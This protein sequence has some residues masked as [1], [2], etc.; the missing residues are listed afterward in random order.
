MLPLFVLAALLESAHPAPDR[1]AAPADRVRVEICETGLLTANAWPLA[2]P[3]AATE[4]F[5]APAFAF[6]RLPHKYIDT[7]VRADRPNPFLLRAVARVTLPAGE[8]RLLLRGR[9]AARLFVDGRLVLNTPFPPSLGDGSDGRD[10]STWDYLNLGPDFRFAPPGNREAWCRFKSTGAEHLVVLE[11]V[12]GGVIG[13]RPRR[14]ELG[15]T[16][17]VVSPAGSESFALLGPGQRVPYTDAAWP[18]FAAAE[19]TRLAKLDADRRAAAFASEKGPWDARR[20]D[21]RAW[22]AANPP[23]P[24]PP[25]PKGFTAGNPVDHFVAAKIAAAPTG[26]EGTVSYAKDVRPILEAKCFSCH[27]GAKAKAGL[28]LDK[29]SPAVVP[30]KPD[31]SDLIARATATDAA[32]VMPPKGERLTAGEV[33]LLKQW[34]AEGALYTERPGRVT[35]LTDD[36]AFLRRVTLG[37]VGVVPT[38]DEIAAFR[39]DRAPDRRAKVI[40]RL[41]VDPR[42]AGH[43]VGYWQDVLAEN[44]NILNPTLNNTGPF[45]WWLHEAYRDNKPF[46]VMVTE[47]VRMRG[48]ERGGGPAGF[49]VASENDVPMAEKAVTVAA[50]FLGANMKCARCHD[51]PA[52]RAT[53]QELFQLAGLLAGKPLKVPATSSVPLDKLGGGGR[54]PLIK[55]TLKPGTTV[56]PAWPFADFLKATA[57]APR[58]V[59]SRDRLAAWLTDPRNERFAQVV[60]NR[61]WKRL[62][63][64]GLVEPADDWERGEPSHPELLTYLARELVRSGYD[65]RHVERLI[66][67]SHAYQRAA[68]PGRAAPDPFF[69]SPVRRRLTAEQV[70][71]SLFA[72]AGKPLNV[73]EVS[74]DID[75][76]RDLGN[77]ISLGVPRRAWEF[78]STSNERDRPSLALPRVQAVVDA[79]AAF[80]WRATRPDALTDR[81]TAPDVLQ[82][83]ALSNGTVA[84]WLTRLSDDHAVA[85]LALEAKTPEAFVDALFLRVLTR[86]PTARERAALV[87]HVSVGFEGRVLA[88]PPVP[89]GAGPRARPRYVSWSNH[90]TPGANDLKT[91][92]ERQARAGDPPTARLTADWRTRAE[93]ALWA[94]LNAPEFVF[95]P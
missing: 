77:S 56:D 41:L 90:L 65:L 64:M 71:D 73:G 40:D 55:V 79:L 63:G 69:A 86:P 54:Q 46:D 34:I 50:A 39:A 87:D 5:D 10:P 21:A 19:E 51:A 84:V 17:V 88:S 23:P 48:S 81:D 83:A 76:A 36:L 38:P 45:R 31:A 62:M 11:T 93:D 13:K 94:L 68:D 47:L 26:K 49:G 58:S 30:G 82:P 2:V 43:W 59:E 3:P 24:V 12:V 52:N 6:T 53:Q 4:T 20:A 25:L 22:L 74:L 80:G 35:T 16:V 92:F 78:A 14:Q 7:G 66:L 8:H 57:D 42:R 37:T 28:A 29:A 32:E 85:R 33:K 91:E 67:N 89:A 95:T 9:G 70:V 72:A 15:E 18:A 1:A 44:P 27:Q 61:V 75:G 60:V